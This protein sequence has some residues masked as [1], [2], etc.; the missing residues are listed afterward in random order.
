MTVH[1]TSSR[2]ETWPRWDDEIHAAV[3]AF[4]ARHGLTPNILLASSVTFARID[5]VAK[6]QRLVDAEGRRPDEH[7]YAPVSSFAGADYVLEFCLD[8]RLPSSA[9]VL[10]HD[11]GGSGEGEPVDVPDLTG[12]RRPA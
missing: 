12:G 4:R 1:R 3:E 10:V 8:E 2:I 5:L 11:D 6:K 9:L 7:E